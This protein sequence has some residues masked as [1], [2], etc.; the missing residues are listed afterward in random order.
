MIA[1]L[2]PTTLYYIDTNVTPGTTYNYVVLSV[3]TSGNTPMFPST[4]QVT[5]PSVSTSTPKMD[6][7]EYSF[8]TSINNFRVQNGLPPFQV[9]L[10]LENA[11]QWMANDIV[12][13]NSEAST[14]SLGR[15]TA[16]RLA[17]FG[18]PYTPWGEYL[19]ISTDAGGT[20]VGLYNQWITTCI[21]IPT[22][23]CTYGFLNL[24]KTKTFTVVGIARAYNA[25]TQQWDWVVDLGAV[26]DP[27]I[28]FGPG[29]IPSPS[30]SYFAA[31]PSTLFTGATT[32]LGWNETGANSTTIDHG[33][34]DVTN[35]GTNP[36]NKSVSPSQTTTYTL[37]AT[38]PG[39]STIATST[40]V[41]NSLTTPPTAPT[42]LT[43]T[44]ISPSE[45]DLS[46][47]ASTASNGLQEYILSRNGSILAT[48]QN[49]ILNYV[50][51]S[52]A[53]STVYDYVIQAVDNLGNHSAS[54]SLAQAMT[55]ASVT[56]PTTCVPSSGTFTACYYSGITLS[57][58][59]VLINLANPLNYYWVSAFPPSPVP[60]NGFSARYQGNFNF[61][62][63][64]HAFS[65]IASDGVRIYIDG[66]KVL[67]E[68]KDGSL[69]AYNFSQTMTQGS[70]LVTVEFYSHTGTP[71]IHVAWQ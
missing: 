38:N 24:M 15:S 27:T 71:A 51:L 49:N 55:P 39:G 22:G 58:N 50:D 28:A 52:V 54:S 26:T 5:I 17:A 23:G 1:T 18:Y 36:G 65:V 53:P 42:N 29:I 70:H 48:V 68:W 61:T 34:G 35:A 33:I 57:G 37:T 11:G 19:P 40:V 67:D 43:A 31:S 47:G 2:S 12:T 44:A 3:D 7:E 32:T 20:G 21:P 62:A 25:T 4:L 64:T 66:V 59:P 46:W 45:I 60:P 10:A 56:V 14:D 30:I 6:I 16:A 8:L 9:S 69:S 63:G 41:V 13:H